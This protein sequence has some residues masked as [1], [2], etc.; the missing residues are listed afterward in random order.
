VELLRTLRSLKS[1]DGGKIQEKLDRKSF[2]GCPHPSYSPD[3]SPCDF[4]FFGMAKEKMKD[5]EFRTVQDILRRLTEIWN[6]FTFEDVQSR[7]GEWQIRLTWVMENGEE[8]DFEYN[9]KNGNLLNRRSQGIL[10][11]RLFGHPV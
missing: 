2:G 11:A 10:S 9:Q 5:H 6:N 4:W 1:H 8:Y 3:L 7:F